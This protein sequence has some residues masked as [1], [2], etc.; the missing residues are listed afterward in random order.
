MTD[1]D[2]RDDFGDELTDALLARS[3]PA[4]L[5][6]TA[7]TVE[8][9]VRRVRVRRQ[10]LA[11][12]CAAVIAGSGVAVVALH[13]RGT[14]R[15]NVSTSPPSTTPT[16]GTVPSS[17]DA[18]SSGI[19]DWTWVSADHGWALVRTPCAA[20]VCM[21]LRETTDGGRAWTTVRTPELLDPYAQLDGGATCA[22]RLC[23]FGV[24]FV[25]SH[26]GWLFGPSF[27]QTTDGG[28]TWTR[29]A[30]PDVIDVEASL[31]VALR[32]TTEHWAD[33]DSTCTYHVERE[34]LG[35]NAWHQV[36]TAVPDNPSLIVL[37]NDAYV[38]SV[39]PIGS[40]AHAE[41]RRSTDGGESW[42]AMTDPCTVGRGDYNTMS[43][44]EGPDGVLVVL[45]SDRQ[46]LQP[47]VRVSGDG[48]KTFG[49]RRS[50]PIVGASSGVVRATSA[51]TMLVAY[52]AGS[53]NAV[54]T[55]SD[56]GDT[57]RTTLRPSVPATDAVTLGW[58]TT[59]TAR[60]AFDTDAM[61][62]TRDSGVHWV[63]NT[64]AP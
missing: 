34:V 46:L 35:T 41:L 29:V 39:P 43:G 10:L 23:A 40:S 53:T 19:A 12:A 15:V 13:G 52:R 61:W 7:A 50:V 21:T 48:G 22:V 51:Q 31:G 59:Q 38:V 16:T 5:A 33:C 54:L 18:N 11:A 45:C 56:G 14:A 30:G 4:E 25:T 64:V 49:P 26:V 6:D 63:L 37:G 9:R 42:A 57:W 62:T 55:S 47:F 20:T 36:T 1:D 44:S 60:A 2:L 32:L 8:R 3:R 28:R 58:E 27:L 17:A 24:R